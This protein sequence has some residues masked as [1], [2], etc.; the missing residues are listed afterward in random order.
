MCKEWK[1]ERSWGRGGI[2]APELIPRRGPPVGRDG[3]RTGEG[4]GGSRLR[5]AFG[6]QERGAVWQPRQWVG[7][8]ARQG[9]GSVRGGRFGMREPDPS[10]SRRLSPPSSHLK[11]ALGYS[12]HVPPHGAGGCGPGRALRRA[13]CTDLGPRTGPGVPGRGL[14]V[15]RVRPGPWDGNERPLGSGWASTT[16]RGASGRDDCTS[17]ARLS[18]QPQL[19]PKTK[20]LPTCQQRRCSLDRAARASERRGGGGAGGGG[21]R[22]RRKTTPPPHGA[23]PDGAPRSIRCA[24]EH[25][26]RGGGTTPC[27]SEAG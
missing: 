17:L 12:V 2:R 3:G 6:S 15:E 8:G 18:P 27:A 13:E 9:G 21:A 10:S 16:S 24:Q 5:W 11:S 1:A 19:Q 23:G 20:T 26:E 7:D 4:T 25:P 22:R 14:G